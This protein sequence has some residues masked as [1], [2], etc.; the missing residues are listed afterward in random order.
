MV[1]EN[2]VN[3]FNFAMGKRFPLHVEILFWR[4]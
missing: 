4:Y 2:A 3:Q 1:A